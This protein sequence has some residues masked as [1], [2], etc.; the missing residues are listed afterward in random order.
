MSVWE[1]NKYK[2]HGDKF[3]IDSFAR[4]L[5]ITGV[6]RVVNPNG[7]TIKSTHGTA[8]QRKGWMDDPVQVQEEA[9]RPQELGTRVDRRIIFNGTE[10]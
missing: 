5:L 4:L 6:S 8:T 3:H 7:D 2:T 1:D 9:G 10:I